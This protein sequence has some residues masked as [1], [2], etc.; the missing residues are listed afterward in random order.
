MS[1]KLFNGKIPEN[2]EMDGYL[3]KAG[4]VDGNKGLSERFFTLGDN[5]IAYFAVRYTFITAA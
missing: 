2:I 5:M 3:V 1:K 4:G